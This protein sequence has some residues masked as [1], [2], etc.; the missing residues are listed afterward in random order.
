MKLHLWLWG[1]C[2]LTP[3]GLC[4]SLGNWVDEIESEFRKCQLSQ[5]SQILWLFSLTIAYLLYTHTGP[6]AAI[7]L[8]CHGLPCFGLALRQCW[9]PPREHKQK[10]D[11]TAELRLPA[12]R[13]DACTA[14]HKAARTAAHT[15]VCTAARTAFLPIRQGPFTVCPTRMCHFATSPRLK[16]DVIFI[17][18]L[19]PTTSEAR[20][21]VTKSLKQCG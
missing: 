6:V 20:R 17:S 11:N 13:T 14:A 15:A 5:K 3:W 10:R 1:S 7:R 4:F 12:A 21:L 16:V 19:I 18:F 9:E 8:G 2:S